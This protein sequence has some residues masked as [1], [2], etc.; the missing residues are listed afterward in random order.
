MASEKE[1]SSAS[2]DVGV[3][4]SPVC[5]ALCR[6]GWNERERLGPR[7]AEDRFGGVPNTHRLRRTLPSAGVLFSGLWV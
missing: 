4:G 5:P 1:A 3:S 7:E 2:A 6:L